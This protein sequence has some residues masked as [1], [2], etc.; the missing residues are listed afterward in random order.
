MDV[1][2]INKLLNFLP[3]T[4]TECQQDTYYDIAD[5]TWENLQQEIKDWIE[6]E[7]IGQATINTPKTLRIKRE[8]I[9]EILTSNELIS[10]ILSNCD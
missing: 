2:N 8:T 5:A 3:G 6:N 7:G 10:Q 9:E 4:N 1:A